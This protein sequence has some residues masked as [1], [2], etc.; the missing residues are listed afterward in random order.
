MVHC[1]PFLIFCVCD[2][3]GAGGEAAPDPFLPRSSKAPSVPAPGAFSRLVAT[4][5]FESAL[6]VRLQAYHT[7]QL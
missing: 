7:I 2:V 1:A 5:G 6:Q 4:S 3:V